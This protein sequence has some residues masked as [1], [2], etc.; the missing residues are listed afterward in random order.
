MSDYA[1]DVPTEP[2][3][4]RPPDVRNAAIHLRARIGELAI[5]MVTT[6][7]RRYM[8]ASRPLLTQLFEDNGVLW[9]FV[10]TDGSLASE[11]ES[12]PRVSVSYC[13]P[14]RGLYVSLSGYARLV[15]DP[16]RMLALWDPRLAS[17]FPEGLADPRLALLRVDVDHGEYW[18]ERASRM[19]GW[20][21]RAQ[22][23][24]RGAPAP[25]AEHHRL[26]LR[27]RQAGT[28]PNA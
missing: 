22:A 21:A 1:C 6:T 28:R 3:S 24:L 5:A 18:D 11:I 17:W 23:A 8:P 4:E 12:N 2:G 16:E 25:P 14:A 27:T 15:H 7:D 19:V 13:D 26:T 10:P 20:L 9:F